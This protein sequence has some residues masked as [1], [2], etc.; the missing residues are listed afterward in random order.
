MANTEKVN[1]VI[2]D[3]YSGDEFKVIM[4]ENAMRAIKWLSKTCNLEIDVT[5]KDNTFIDLDF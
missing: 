4:S 5:I 3:H 2:Y 1:V